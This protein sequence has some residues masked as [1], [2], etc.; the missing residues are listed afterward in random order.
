MRDEQSKIVC[1]W[2]IEKD[3][4]VTENMVMRTWTRFVALE[5]ELWYVIQEQFPRHC[6]LNKTK[7]SCMSLDSSV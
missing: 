1:V 2:A 3:V 7:F 6:Q 5:M 4:A